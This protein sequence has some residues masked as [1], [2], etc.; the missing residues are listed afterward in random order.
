MNENNTIEKMKQMRM[1][2]MAD[3]YHQSLTEHLYQDMSTDELLTF[4]VDNEWEARQNKSIDNLIRLANFKQMAA[5]TDIDYHTSRN[6]DRGLFERLLGLAFIKNRTNVILTGATGSGK[7]FLAQSL[8]IKACQHK[9]RT[10]YYQ[11]ARFFDTVK[12]AKLD[13]SYHKLLKK[14]EKTQV[15]ILDDFGLAPMDTQARLAL[16]DVME[17][18]Y[19]KT[20][21]IIASQIPVNKWHAAI[22]DDSIADAVLDR[23][24]YSSHRIE[25]EGNSMRSKKK[26]QN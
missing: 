6:L 22:G 18:R 23:L 14:L 12:L 15:L 1:N 9:Y 3:L 25:L 13:G 10:L 2:T 11:T 4:L 5:A 20:S 8:G 26:I 17:D 21:T 24:V 7:S 16:M 19:D